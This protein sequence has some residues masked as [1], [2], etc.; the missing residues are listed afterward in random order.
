MIVV[1]VNS[2]F[3]KSECILRTKKVELKT[4]EK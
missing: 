3:V 1:F 2:V 4:A